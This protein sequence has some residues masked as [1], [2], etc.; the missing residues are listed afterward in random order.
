MSRDRDPDQ[1]PEREQDNFLPYNLSLELVS[2][3]PAA[4]DPESLFR[5]V[6]QGVVVQGVTAVLAFPQTRDELLQVDF[7]ASFLE[8]PFLSVIDQDEP[9]RTQVRV[10][11]GPG[12]ARALSGR[13][14][15]APALPGPC[16]RAETVYEP[17]M[18]LVLEA[19]SSGCDGLG[20][21]GHD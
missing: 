14:H 16:L 12:A 1:D 9:L 20:M 11:P 8:I 5:S 3:Q 15:V 2:R 17:E 13:T 21:G 6:C 18:D 7:M 10:S 19:L 4:A